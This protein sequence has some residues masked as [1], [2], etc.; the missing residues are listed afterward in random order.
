LSSQFP[1]DG[2]H[3]GQQ[4]LE[5]VLGT[6]Q[7]LE[8]FADLVQLGNQPQPKIAGKAWLWSRELFERLHHAPWAPS[9][10]RGPP[11][12]AMRDQRSDR[13]ARPGGLP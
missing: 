5:P 10:C 12:D 3:C 11:T 6:G 13:T 7:F 9:G 1:A 8:P 2:Q 4:F